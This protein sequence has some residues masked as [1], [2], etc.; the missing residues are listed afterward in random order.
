MTQWILILI[1]MPVLGGDPGR[2][3]TMVMV[4]Q[5]SCLKTAMTTLQADLEK[6]NALT[7]PLCMTKEGAAA[8]VAAGKCHDPERHFKPDRIDVSCEGITK[9]PQ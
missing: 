2:M 1:T 8:L 4:D 6:G 7:Q 5:A 3:T 9:G